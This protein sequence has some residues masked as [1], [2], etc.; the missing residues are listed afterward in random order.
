MAID[1]T[2]C[3]SVPVQAPEIPTVPAPESID[4][5]RRYC[6]GLALHTHAQIAQHILADTSG[7]WTWDG[8]IN[9]A[10]YGMVGTEK[11][12]YGYGGMVPVHRYMYDTLVGPIPEEYHAHH[13]C[14]YR[15]CWHPMHLEAVT[16]KEHSA[17]HREKLVR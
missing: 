16:P 3:V 1:Y 4:L 6:S 10:G 15:A 14:H 11:T 13:R 17:R 5:V 2:I 8:H 7:C 12:A 9:E